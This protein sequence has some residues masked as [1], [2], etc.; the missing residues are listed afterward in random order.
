MSQSD[1]QYRLD[2]LYKADMDVLGSGK[3]SGQV[4]CKSTN[5]KVEQVT[6]HAQATFMKSNHMHFSIF[7]SASKMEAEV[8]QMVNKIYGG[9]K[10]SC[11][12]TVYNMDDVAHCSMQAY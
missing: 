1:I 11:G 9:N 12:S 4:W 2:E 3:I 10:E 6:K 8:V 7:C 5:S